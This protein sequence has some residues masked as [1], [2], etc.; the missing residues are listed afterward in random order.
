MQNQNRVVGITRP[1]HVI[2]GFGRTAS[3]V[4][5][6]QIELDNGPIDQ[7]ANLSD[8][9]F[10]FFF[11]WKVCCFRTFTQSDYTRRFVSTVLYTRIGTVK[12]CFVETDRIDGGRVKTFSKRSVFGRNK[13]SDRVVF[14]FVR[15]LRSKMYRYVLYYLNDPNDYVLQ[16]GSVG[17]VV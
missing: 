5:A 3:L 11:V 2:T 10:K 4:K 14:F 13:I 9:K 12:L 17:I 8:L 15:C 7:R 6:K 16:P 1:N